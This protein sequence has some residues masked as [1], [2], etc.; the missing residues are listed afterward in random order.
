MQV[1]K[2]RV[3]LYAGA[4]ITLDSRPEKEWEETEMKMKNLQNLLIS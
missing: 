4:G 3:R 2:D 1:F